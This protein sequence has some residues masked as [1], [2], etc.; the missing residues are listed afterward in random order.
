MNTYAIRAIVRKDLMVTL[1]NKGVMIPLIVVPL[2]MF[3]VIPAMVAL[4]PLL[5]TGPG[6][7]LADLEQMLVQMPPVLQAKLAAY[8]PLQQLVIMALVYFLAPLYLIVP[9]MVASVIAADSFAGEKERKTLEALLYTP[10]TDRELLLGKLLAAWLPAVGVALGGFVVYSIVANLAAWPIM[11]RIFF[12]PAMWFI[13][14][15]WVAPAV[16]ALGLMVTVLISTRAQGFQD[17]YQMGAIVVL[18]LILL[19][20]GQAAGVIYFSTWLVALL[21]AIFWLVDALLLWW[22][23]RW[24]RRAEIFR[25]L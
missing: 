22:G 3:L 15:L 10:T 13:L 19:V 9:L 25:R 6:S 5:G 8:A 7:P 20:V 17:A 1:R 4:A 18:P 11:G 14:A 12:P 24:L 16:A 23:G 21:G 2:I